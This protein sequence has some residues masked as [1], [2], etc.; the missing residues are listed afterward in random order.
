MGAGEGMQN[1]CYYEPRALMKTKRY[2][3]PESNVGAI[4]KR[5]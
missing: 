1:E 3:A 2:E 4:R 5:G